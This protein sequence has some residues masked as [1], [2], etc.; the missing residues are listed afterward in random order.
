MSPDELY[1]VRLPEL[2]LGDKPLQLGQWYRD[3]G[4]EIIVGDR[5]L[6]V[7]ADGV[8][9]DIPSPVSGRLSQRLVER[10]DFLAP[11]Q[12]LAVLRLEEEE[13]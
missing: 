2:G 7:I 5:L 4:D 11:Q 1:E 3:V 8:A 10:D 13:A 6:E 9:I 12:R